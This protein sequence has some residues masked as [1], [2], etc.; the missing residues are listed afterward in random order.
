MT[1]A[2]SRNWRSG[3]S[4]SI[5]KLAASVMPAAVI[6]PEVSGTRSAMAWRMVV[7]FALVQ[8]CPT[9]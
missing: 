7:C 4:A 9:P 8:T 2:S 1:N 3:T 6:A 5:P